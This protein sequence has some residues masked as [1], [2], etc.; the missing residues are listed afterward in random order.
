MKQAVAIVTAVTWPI[1]AANS[2]TLKRTE[3]FH[4]LQGTYLVSFLQ[5][6]S[7]IYGNKATSK[8]AEVI[9]TVRR[10]Y[11]LWTDNDINSPCESVLSHLVKPHATADNSFL[12][13]VINL[14]TKLNPL[15]WHKNISAH[16]HGTSN[17]RTWYFKCSHSCCTWRAIVTLLYV[18]NRS[19]LSFS[20]VQTSVC[21]SA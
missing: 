13:I 20:V 3:R 19:S 4:S 17:D 10:R 18:W 11:N 16:R 12:A 21:S 9:P 5:S 8:E 15:A 6:W 14:Q 2:S 1:L 7:T